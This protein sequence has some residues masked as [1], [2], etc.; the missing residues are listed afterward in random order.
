LASPTHFYMKEKKD[1][2][3]L[4]KYPHI[5]LPLKNS[6]RTKWIEKYITSPNKIKEHAFLP[7]IHK[8][9]KV[10]KFR[11][12]YCDKDGLVVKTII[13][14]T[15]FAARHS[16]NKDRELYYASHLDSLIFS[17]YAD[18][19]S[20]KYDA[21]LKDNNLH[22]VVNAYRPIPIDTSN[23]TSPNKCN[24]DFANDVFKYILSYEQD[25]FVVIAF[26]IKS[27]FDNLNHAKLR[28]S[29]TALLGDG[30][31]MSADH[32]NVFKNITRFNY[33]DIVDLFEQFKDRI[34]IQ[35]KG[36]DG[37]M[38]PLKR[39]KVAEI[40]FM[41]NQGAIAFCTQKE[42]LKYKNKLLK[43]TKKTLK[44][45]VL[46]NR[47]FGIPQ[48]SPISSVLAN[49]YL[50]GFDK[51]VN[52]HLSGRGI[53]RRYS[54]D[55][56]V[57][58]PTSEKDRI[59]KLIT[60][61]IDKDFKLNIQSTKT[62]IF[63]FRRQNNLLHCGQEFKECINWNKNF[64]YLGFEFDGSA[65]LLK[66][67]S[68]A[69]YYRKMKRTIFRAKRH[70]RKPLNSHRGEI[71]KRRIL[72]KFSY[73]GA[74]RRRKWIK[75]PKTGYF[76]KSEHYDWGNFLSYATKASK[77]MVRNKIKQQ[78]KNHWNKLHQLLIK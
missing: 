22:E 65:V 61:T 48:G 14:D 44:D 37:K 70:S 62:Q 8:T 31:K 6:D 40:K 59:I 53:Y 60:E 38:L 20:T 15:E 30:E 63:H 2:F 75:E 33:V 46:V 13:G 35:K 16:D 69:G 39:G 4:K 49:I 29:W 41:R 19:L 45:G 10:R 18:Q 11:K 58:C 57:V 3:K 54:D 51:I 9:S 76:K 23:P 21:L 52:E 78:I 27:F 36:K 50:Y 74:Q 26:D 55:M 71:F 43:N 5:G 1:W 64:I 73:K 24:I 28:G 34:F 67:A 47:D 7:F 17:Y 72:K 56:V 25:E 42:F 68:L 12:Q 66:S 77:V 32:F